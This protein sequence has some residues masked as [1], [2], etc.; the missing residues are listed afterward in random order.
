MDLVHPNRLAE[1]TQKVLLNLHI[2]F[3]RLRSHIPPQLVMMVFHD[4]FNGGRIP[5]IGSF[6]NIKITTPVDLQFARAVLEGRE[7]A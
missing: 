3:I 2:D 6:E 1:C 4:F 7:Q 5:G